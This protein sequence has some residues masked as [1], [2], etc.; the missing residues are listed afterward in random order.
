MA[1]RDRLLL[2]VREIL[3]REWDPIGLNGDES[4]CGEYDSYGRTIC[5]W[6]REGANE[7]R[8]A[9]HLS[10]LQRVSMGM[11]VIDEDLHCR[12]ARRLLSLVE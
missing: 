5:Q 8:L 10:Q 12:I 11:S 3:F 6:L 1:K 4:C 7:H 9:S 2:A